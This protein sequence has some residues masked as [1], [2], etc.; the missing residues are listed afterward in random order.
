MSHL[1]LDRNVYSAA[2]GGDGVKA[3]TASHH[4]DI[5]NATIR[6]RHLSSSPRDYQNPLYGN[7]TDVQRKPVYE[8]L[9]TEGL[10]VFFC[11]FSNLC[12]CTYMCACVLINIG[13]MSDVL[14]YLCVQRIGRLSGARSCVPGL[15][16]CS[17]R[18]WIRQ[19]HDLQKS[20]AC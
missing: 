6:L 18:L 1:F 17:V 12:V 4:R 3:S 20:T 19:F 13:T 7:N 11:N 15:V 5:H 2:D 10:S 9:Y 8:T 16:C 14:L